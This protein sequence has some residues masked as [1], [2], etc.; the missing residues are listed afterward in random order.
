MHPIK[1]SVIIPCYNVEEYLEQCIESVVTQTLKEIEVICVDDGSSDG[2]SDMLD[3]LAR[4]YCN[5]KVL[6]K[7]NGGLS[8]ARNIGF[9]VANGKYVLFL[10]S[11]DF[12]IKENALESLYDKAVKENL[13]QLFYGTEVIF[14]NEL[15]R[16][17]N[18]RYVEYYKYNK[19]YSDVYNGKDLFV[20]LS[21]N[22]DFKVNACM[23][24]FSRKFLLVHYKIN[25]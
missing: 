22:S 16:E 23:Q 20:M 19:K 11:D 9:D 13:D 12:L 3:L 24:L 5:I 8:K 4:R 21:D 15:V 18:L 10:D 25:N 7:Q 2:T 1:I 17:E 6:H 14:Q